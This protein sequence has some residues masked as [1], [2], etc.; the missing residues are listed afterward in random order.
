MGMQTSGSMF[1]SVSDQNDVDLNN[2][3]DRLLQH[4][5]IPGIPS[6]AVISPHV[7]H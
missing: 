6:L 3:L 7:Q 1:S 2:I 4:A 5:T